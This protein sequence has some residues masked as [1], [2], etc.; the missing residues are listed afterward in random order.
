MC[1]A[2]RD[3]QTSMQLLGTDAIKL[4]LR[5]HRY[6]SLAYCTTPDSD[7]A[8]ATHRFFSSTSSYTK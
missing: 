6:K 5:P 2:Q 1:V 8:N 3:L 4:C 7:C